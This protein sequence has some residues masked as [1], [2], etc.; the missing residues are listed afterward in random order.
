MKQKTNLTTLTLLMCLTFFNVL[1]AQPIKHLAPVEDNSEIVSDSNMVSYV[2]PLNSTTHFISPETITYVDISSEDVEGDLPEEKICRVKPIAGKLKPG[3]SF[4]ITIVTPAFMNVYK[5]I[6]QDETKH[7]AA[8]HIIKIYAGDGIDLE[9]E[10]YLSPEDFRS[11]VDDASKKKRRIF[12]LHSDRYGLSLILNNIFTDKAHLVLDLSLLNKSRLQFD[13]DEIRFKIKDKKNLDATVS[14]DIELQPLY[15]THDPLKPIHK[16]RRSIF[17]FEKFTFPE[18]KVL[19]IEVTEK[20]I[21]GRKITLNV[22]Y[23]QVL[24]AVVIN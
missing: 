18:D 3:D 7:Q 16:A 22:D 11:I 13:I 5:L 20:Q 15:S 8:N 4:T 17:A 21:S 19:S 24:Q 2:I 23:K 9:N 6:V 10:D 1:T 14:Q 12:N